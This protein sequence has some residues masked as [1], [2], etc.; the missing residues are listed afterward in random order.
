MTSSCSDEKR[1]HVAWH[2]HSLR[3]LEEAG[4]PK[5]R[6]EHALVATG[7]KDVATAIKWLQNHKDDPFVT[8]SGSRQFVLFLTPKGALSESLN[9]FWQKTLD[10]CGPNAIHD[11]FPHLTLT[12][13]FQV[14][15][16]R[17]PAMLEIL[18]KVCQKFLAKK[19]AQLR[20]F[21]HNTR[22]YMALFLEENACT[23]LADLTTKFAN[24]MKA[25]LGLSVPVHNGQFHL[26]LAYQFENVLQKKLEKISKD[27]NLESPC[28]WELQLYSREPRI[29]AAKQIR[30]VKYHYAAV[31]KTELTIIPG[32]Y[33]VVNKEDSPYKDWLKGYCHETGRSGIFPANFTVQSNE[34]KCWCLHR[35]F[36]LADSAS[37]DKV[38]GRSYPVHEHVE[39]KTSGEK[40]QSSKITA[41]QLLTRSAGSVSIPK[42]KSYPIMSGT[43]TLPRSY[44][45][46]TSPRLMQS[47]D[48]KARRIFLIRHAERVDTTFGHTWVGQ[49]FDEQGGYHRR[50]LN[51]PRRLPSRCGGAEC[52]KTDSPITEIGQCQARLTGESLFAHNIQ[53]T[54]VFASPAFRCIQTAEAV[55]DGLKLKG[56]MKLKLDPGLY[57]WL[58]WC[59]GKLPQWLTLEELLAFGVKI[60]TKYEP[61]MSADD[62]NLRETLDQFHHRSYNFMRWTIDNLDDEDRNILI[63]AHS[64]SL[65]AC[66]RQLTGQRPRPAEKFIKIVQNVPYCALNVLEETN[67]KRWAI[68]QPP[69]PSLI[70]CGNSKMDWKMFVQEDERN[71]YAV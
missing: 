32:Q 52:Y 46:A 12:R 3:E 18:D 8:D 4:F 14:E 20:L 11:S 49:F 15:D 13:L 34:Y 63:V 16:F 48:V 62:F 43:S 65:E 2:K 68:V 50:N 5:D 56:K 47:L 41:E 40:D 6:A 25:T 29:A 30:V 36:K 17:V 67:S 10:Q 7:H 42:N 31:N 58:A 35:V 23:W 37:N 55:L 19:Q 24:Q 9:E 70:H 38:D 26:T 21:H 53:I 28:E 71:P 60:D 57:E 27:I 51:M 69:I 44:S 64:P 59:K 45:H 66:S 39:L 33:V 22:G 54:K 1:D 61:F